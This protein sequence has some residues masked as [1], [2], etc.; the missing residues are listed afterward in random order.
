VK[1][2]GIFGRIQTEDRSSRQWMVAFLVRR[3]S[4]TR[5]DLD[6]GQR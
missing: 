5:T 1:I 6:Y 2:S 3:A 4:D